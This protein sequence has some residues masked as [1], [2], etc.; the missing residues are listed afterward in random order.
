MLLSDEHYMFNRKNVIILST[1]RLMINGQI[2][3]L[4]CSFYIVGIDNVFIYDCL[5]LYI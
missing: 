4:N 1:A 2:T 5:F 3:V